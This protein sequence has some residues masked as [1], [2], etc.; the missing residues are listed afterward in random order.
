MCAQGVVLHCTR[1]DSI[2]VKTQLKTSKNSWEHRKTSKIIW[3]YP[4]N[5]WGPIIDD[6]VQFEEDFNSRTKKWVGSGPV[7]WLSQTRPISRSPDGDI[8]GRMW[9]VDAYF[10]KTN[11]SQTRILHSSEN[12]TWSPFY[13]T[14]HVTLPRNNLRPTVSESTRSIVGKNL[15]QETDFYLW[16]RQRLNTMYY[17]LVRE[18]RLNLEETVT[19]HHRLLSLLN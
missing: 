14:L 4:E 8:N 6:L 15:T 2:K 1:S 12:N 5:N 3:Y 18:G 11:T 13:W 16:C 9:T 17:A 19:W 7:R 10:C